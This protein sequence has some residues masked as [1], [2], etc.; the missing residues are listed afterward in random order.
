L[1]FANHFFQSPRVYKKVAEHFVLAKR[2]YGRGYFV[3]FWDYGCDSFGGGFGFFSL[4]FE[5]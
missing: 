4:K 2:R 1:D 5:R 3:R